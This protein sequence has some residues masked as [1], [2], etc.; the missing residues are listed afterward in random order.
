MNG[1]P[2]SP[3]PGFEER[4]ERRRYLVER[5]EGLA[6]EARGEQ[7][8]AMVQ[9]IFGEDGLRVLRGLHTAGAVKRDR[10]A[11]P[12]D[13]AMRNDVFLRMAL[14]DL[15]ASAQDL[16]HIVP[17]LGFLG[18]APDN[19]YNAMIVYIQNPNAR[20][21]RSRAEWTAARRTVR[22]G[23]RPLLTLF[24]FGPFRVKYDVAD[25]DDIATNTEDAEHPV[26]GVLDGRS[27]RR[28]LRGVISTPH[29]RK[30]WAR[31]DGDG[32][33][34]REAQSTERRAAGMIRRTGTEFEIA[35]NVAV[36]LPAQVGTLCHALAH[37][38][39]GHLGS[40]PLAVRVP[41]ERTPAP[42]WPSRTTMPPSV[43][44]LE[45]EAVAFLLCAQLGMIAPEPEYIAGFID[46]VPLGASPG[47]E[48]IVRAASAASAVS[49]LVVAA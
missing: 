37:L 21:W 41:G 7:R 1:L 46:R 3:I 10:A 38:F 30:V 26:S 32:I 42:R 9:N 24:P 35:L 13:E 33:H 43:E 34:V 8:S 22:A 40:D 20:E 12:A 16:A 29:W 4:S 18:R 36:P 25:T 11:E 27:G 45:A 6:E 44:E 17:L 48:M 19:V 39:L 2:W 5:I 31:L 28:E 47:V 23:A 49:R 15:F 14:D